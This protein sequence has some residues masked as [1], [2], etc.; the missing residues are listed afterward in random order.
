MLCCKGNGNFIMKQIKNLVS[1]KK[2][3]TYIKQTKIEQL[4]KFW[5]TTNGKLRVDYQTDVDNDL[6]DFIK[7]RTIINNMQQKEMIEQ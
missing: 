4:R 6:L 2:Y 5:N 1:K 3:E 7:M